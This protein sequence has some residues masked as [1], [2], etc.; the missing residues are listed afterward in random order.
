M[1]ADLPIFYLLQFLDGGGAG[2]GRGGLMCFDDVNALGF[3]SVCF[4]FFFFF[5]LLDRG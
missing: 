5:S 3:F 4:P 1:V 2:P